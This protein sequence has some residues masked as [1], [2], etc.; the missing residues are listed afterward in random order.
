MCGWEYT[1]PTY[2]LARRL[3]LP[4]DFNYHNLLEEYNPV[5]QDGEAPILLATCH[6]CKQ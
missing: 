3:L 4:K 6:T 2:S 1:N 5:S